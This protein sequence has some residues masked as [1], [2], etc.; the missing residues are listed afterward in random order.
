MLNR[1]ALLNLGSHVHGLGAIVLGLLGLVWG[2]FAT[3]CQLVHALP[4]SVPHREALAYIVAVPLLLGGGAIQWCRTAQA[5]VVVLAIFY[6]IFALLWV[7]HVV[8]H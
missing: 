5:G 3:V 6:F 8:G 7:P 4:F 2:D 1:R